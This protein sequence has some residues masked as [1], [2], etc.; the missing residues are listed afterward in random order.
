MIAVVNVA[1]IQLAEAIRRDAEMSVRAS[2]GASVIRLARQAATETLLLTT[3]AAAIGIVISFAALRVV[4]AGIPW[5]LTFQ[6]LRPI[7]IDWRAL[8]FTSVTSAL[9]GVGTALTP[10]ATA[11]GRGRA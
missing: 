2:L 7:T 9:V 8:L 3:G 1:N 5:L 6:S 10:I 11:G 4:L